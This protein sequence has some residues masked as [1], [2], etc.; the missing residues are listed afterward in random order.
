MSNNLGTLPADLQAP[1]DDGGCDHL[2]GMTMPSIA[3]PSTLGGTVDVGALPGRAVVFAYP[4]TGRPDVALPDGWDAIPGARGCT[5][6]N[7]AFRDL[8]DAFLKAGASVHGLSTQTPAYQ[9]EMAERLHL[10]YGVLSDS[11][12]ALTDALRLPSLQ[13]DGMRLIKRL[14]LII[15][16]G[17]ITKTFY[18]VF[19]PDRSA[20]PVLDWLRTH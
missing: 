7:C 20:E 9:R 15:E 12:F 13:V 11:H 6:Q 3:L 1:V 5:P 10:P 16:N 17:T 19:P 8:H 18:P 14:T 2:I 4:M